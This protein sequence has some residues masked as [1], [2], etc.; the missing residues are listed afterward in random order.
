[1]ED[2]IGAGDALAREQRGS[3]VGVGL[4]ECERRGR[5]DDVAAER[6]SVVEQDLRPV[7]RAIAEL[8]AHDDAFGEQR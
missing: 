5:V 2:R 6:A 4:R 7:G 8:A 1:M 3:R